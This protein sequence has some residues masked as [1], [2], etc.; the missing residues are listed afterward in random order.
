MADGTTACTERQTP[1]DWAA[2]FQGSFE[3]VCKR[4]WDHLEHKHQLLTPSQVSE[5]TKAPTAQQ[6]ARAVYPEQRKIRV[7]PAKP[8]LGKATDESSPGTRAEWG[9]TPPHHTRQ[10]RSARH[11]RK[12]R[13]WP[14][15]AAN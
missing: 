14:N 5:L 1:S 4:F 7:W 10:R 9:A 8:Q 2:A 13:V 12:H 11:P 6:P 15:A 3:A